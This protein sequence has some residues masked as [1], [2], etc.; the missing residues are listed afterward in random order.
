[1]Q[2]DTQVSA[3]YVIPARTLIGSP[4][5]VIEQL[6]EIVES[7]LA[8]RQVVASQHHGN[9]RR[10]SLRTGSPPTAR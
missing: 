6:D 8:F 3:T 7:L 4:D 9:V 10:D 1:M 5:R 2:G